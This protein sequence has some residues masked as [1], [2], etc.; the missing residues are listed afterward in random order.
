MDFVVIIPARYASTQLP[1][2]PLHDIN[3]KPMVIHVLE[4]AVE[5]GA[6]LIIVATDSEE[7]ARVVE[8]AG[9]E[10]CMTRAD[11]HSGT[12]RLAE[13]VERCGFSDE[14]V[15]V[16]VQCD[17]PMMPSVNIQQVAENLVATQADMATLAAPLKDRERAFDPNTVKVETNRAGFALYFSRAPIPRARNDAMKSAMPSGGH[18]FLHHIGIYVYQAG[19]IR[20]YAH[21]EPGPQE[22]IERLEQLRA[23]WYGDRIHVAVA[24]ALP[25]KGVDTADDLAYVRAALLASPSRSDDANKS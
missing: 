25:G 3:G 18:L 16:N 19:F 14:T 20:R 7:I 1:G 22:Q 15:I 21:R 13:V 6:K 17:E 9:G 12:E 24:K 5:S 11:H 23:L 8:A 2:K 4:R 10:V